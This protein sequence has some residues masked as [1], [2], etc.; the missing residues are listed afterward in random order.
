MNQS[1]VKILTVEVTSFSYKRTLPQRLFSN[2]DGRHGGGFVFDCRCLPN[3]GR[4]EAFREKTG[5]DLDVIQFLQSSAEVTT[6]KEH[7]FGLVTA[8]VEN[9][10][11]R[12][13]EFLSVGFGCTGGQHRSVFLTEQLSLHLLKCFSPR[14]TINVLH[15][16]L[17]ASGRPL[18]VQGAPRDFEQN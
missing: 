4:Q 6:F 3:P 11:H 7:V 17:D 5:L 15:S 10:M 9:Y 12:G 13:F 18:A 14:V 16:N 1:D 8:A 2:Q